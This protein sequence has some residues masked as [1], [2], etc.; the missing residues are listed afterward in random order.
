M[1]QNY[2]SVGRHSRW[3]VGR[4]S[5]QR[6][7]TFWQRSLPRLPYDH[8]QYIWNSDFYAPPSAHHWPRNHSALL[9]LGRLAEQDQTKNT[10]VVAR[11][12]RDMNRGYIKSVTGA[13]RLTKQYWWEDTPS[14]EM[15]SPPSMNAW[16][17]PPQNTHF[18]SI[19]CLCTVSNLSLTSQKLFSNARAH[20][21]SAKFWSSISVK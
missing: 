2:Q 12:G 15:I 14:L 21:A 9:S 16:E 3:N 4:P 18:S 1:L 5:A 19:I 11:G 7:D 10:T 6:V 8:T 17:C 13:H 20:C